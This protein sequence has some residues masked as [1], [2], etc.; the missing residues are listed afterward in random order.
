ML[1]ALICTEKRITACN[2]ALQSVQFE[3][4]KN[5]HLIKEVPE[6]KHLILSA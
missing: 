4:G 3:N 2:S 5:F 6:W 1:F